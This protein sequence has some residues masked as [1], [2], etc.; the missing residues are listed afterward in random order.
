MDV[1]AEDILVNS[2]KQEDHIANLQE[3]FIIL[4]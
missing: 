3:M 4:R 2:P 1:Y